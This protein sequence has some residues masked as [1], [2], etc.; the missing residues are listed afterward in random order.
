MPPPRSPGAP[1]G[2][3]PTGIRIVRELPLALEA[4]TRDP[5]ID[6]VAP[7]II[8]PQRTLVRDSLLRVERGEERT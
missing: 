3:P 2:R 6:E 4:V 7:R 8:T 1:L 5:F